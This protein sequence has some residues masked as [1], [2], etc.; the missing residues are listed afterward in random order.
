MDLHLRLSVTLLLWDILVQCTQILLISSSG[1]F[2][3]H[4]QAGPSLIQPPILQ[5]NC[6]MHGLNQR[7]INCFI[8]EQELAVTSAVGEFNMK[9]HKK[10]FQVSHVNLH[11]IQARWFEFGSWLDD[12]GCEISSNCRHCPPWLVYFDVGK[13]GKK[14]HK[15]K[16]K[17]VK[18]PCTFHSQSIHGKFNG[19]LSVFFKGKIVFYVN[20][21]SA[22]TNL[23]LISW[24]KS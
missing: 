11:F 7:S 23:P 18:V 3:K 8:A 19:I 14:I 12:F 20:I 6:V 9:R 4:S 16:F 10:K 5:K 24:V 15:V 21:N 17:I 13:A 2:R 1:T 22:I